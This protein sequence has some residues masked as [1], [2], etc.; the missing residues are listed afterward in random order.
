MFYMQ[1]DKFE[2]YCPPILYLSL[3]TLTFDMAVLY[4]NVAFSIK[5]L[6]T[7]KQYASYLKKGFTFS[8]NLSQS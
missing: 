8:G 3:S 7:I 4:G 5:V 1:N 2:H 6:A